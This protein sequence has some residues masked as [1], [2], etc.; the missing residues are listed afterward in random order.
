MLHEATILSCMFDPRAHPGKMWQ[1][2]F[3]NEPVV[4][5]S[6][7]AR[8]SALLQILG[9]TPAESVWQPAEEKT[10]S[11]TSPCRT[12]TTTQLW[13]HWAATYLKSWSRSDINHHKPDVLLVFSLTETLG[14]YLTELLLLETKLQENVHIFTWNP[15]ELVLTTFQHKL[16][17]TRKLFCSNSAQNF[18]SYVSVWLHF[19]LFPISSQ[20]GLLEQHLTE[21][22][23]LEP[24]SK[25]RSQEHLQNVSKHSGRVS[26]HLRVLQKIALM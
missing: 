7:D 2:I 14:L 24:K 25:L 6:L 18:L 9:E 23:R 11:F 17:V 10:F 16:P 20:F 22:S 19:P 1:H 8:R 12:R 3:Q 5:G 21:L 15:S 4:S 13:A 26:I